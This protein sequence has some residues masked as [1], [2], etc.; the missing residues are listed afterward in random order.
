[1]AYEESSSPSASLDDG[2]QQT[3]R[4]VKSLDTFLGGRH[5][6][7]R[8]FMARTID[9]C[10]SGL[11]L[12]LSLIFV[13]TAAM[14]EQTAGFVEVIQNPAIASAVLLIIW[15]PFEAF[16]LSSFGT[17]PAKWLFGI[18]VSRPDGAPLSFMAA[19]KRSLL[20]FVQGAGLGL[21]LITYVTQF[22]AYQRLT[23]TGTTRW[24]ASVNAVV[25]HKKWGVIRVIACT[26]A[27]FL[28]LILMSALNAATI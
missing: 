13:S 11:A 27:V 24:D 3:N 7:W 4:L 5:H 20:L 21:P 18:R 14:P 8:R 2:T 28:V 12:F 9:S 15:L 26:A 22:F 19:I 10:T 16:L 25:H 23:R 1:M 6:P 17:T